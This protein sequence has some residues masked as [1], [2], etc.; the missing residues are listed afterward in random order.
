MKHKKNVQKEE[1]EWTFPY[2]D[3]NT[4]PYWSD[5][6]FQPSVAE[7]SC[8]P[9]SK[10][11]RISQAH[12]RS[13]NLCR[14][15][16]CL[17]LADTQYYE[18]TRGMS[19]VPNQIGNLVYYYNKIERGITGGR[20]RKMRGNKY[21]GTIQSTDDG[22]EEVPYRWPGEAKPIGE[23]PKIRGIEDAKPS[24]EPPIMV[25]DQST[26]DPYGDNDHNT[27]RS[28]GVNIGNILRSKNKLKKKKRKGALSLARDLII[29]RRNKIHL[30]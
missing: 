8:V 24:N 17:D 21:T 12:D 16:L 6:K 22:F 25:C 7:F 15:N 13:Y 27:S 11:D 2:M 10:L 18:A 4:G 19:F 20:G 29:G 1:I 30:S 5:G 28:T 14:D 23:K 26:Y 3:C 9:K